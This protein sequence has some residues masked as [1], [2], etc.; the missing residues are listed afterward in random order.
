MWLAVVHYWFKARAA[1]SPVQV[2]LRTLSPLRQQ[3]HPKPAALAAAALA[4]A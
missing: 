1:R 3:R 2:E 4:K